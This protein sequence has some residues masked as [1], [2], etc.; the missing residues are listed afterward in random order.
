MQRNRS[1]SVD[2]GIL[3]PRQYDAGVLARSSRQSVDFG[4]V[5]PKLLNL[6]NRYPA[7]RQSVDVE[8]G[9]RA[10]RAADDVGT[11]RHISYDAWIRAVRVSEL[12][13]MKN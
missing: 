8:R 2:V 3:R 9:R 11:R 1:Q 6:G 5:G 7:R 12:S 10:S 4:N 13:D